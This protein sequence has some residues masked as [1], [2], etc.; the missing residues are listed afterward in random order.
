MYKH[1]LFPPPT[2]T[3]QQSSVESSGTVSEAAPITSEA[4]GRRRDSEEGERAQQITTMATEEVSGAD[5]RS[6]R[7]DSSEMSSTGQGQGEGEVA[8]TTQKTEEDGM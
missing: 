2:H 8:D 5:S 1:L 7:V 4:E 3:Q 6:P